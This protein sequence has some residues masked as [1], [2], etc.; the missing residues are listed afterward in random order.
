MEQDKVYVTGHQHPDTDSIAAAIGYAFFKRANGVKAI[1]CRL[2]KLAKE[3]KYL[4]DRF[5]FEEPM[6]LEDARFKLS[7]IK[8]DKPVTISPE[9]TPWTSTVSARKRPA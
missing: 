7:E 2:G 5:G 8:L 3:T 4:L 6:L 1:P 9:E